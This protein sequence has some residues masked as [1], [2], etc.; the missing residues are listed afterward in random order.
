MTPSK[1]CFLLTA[2]LVFWMLV[3]EVIGLTWWPSILVAVR[4]LG[5][6]A[7]ATLVSGLLYW[8]RR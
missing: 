1:F 7:L 2:G 5:I 6:T 4:P 8:P 3:M